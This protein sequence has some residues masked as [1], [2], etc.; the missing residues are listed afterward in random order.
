M[1]H[2]LAEYVTALH[3]PRAQELS[4]VGLAADYLAKVPTFI[5]EW[6]AADSCAALI[7]ERTE[8]RTD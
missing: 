7:P 4:H 8:W 1:T 2:T 3:D 5:A 6:H